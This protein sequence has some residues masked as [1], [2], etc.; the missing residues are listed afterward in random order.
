VDGG[1]ATCTGF[2][3]RENTYLN[4]GANTDLMLMIGCR[5]DAR[6]GA[7]SS[8]SGRAVAHCPTFG[9]NGLSGVSVKNTLDGMAELVAAFAD[10]AV[11]RQDAIQGADRA[12]IDALVEQGGIDLRGGQI[13]EPGCSQNIEHTAA[14]FRSKGTR[15]REFGRP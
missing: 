14:F 12:K 6:A 3:D 1:S 11:F 9:Q 7:S 10:P 5:P 2:D 15:R 8:N 13:D 4:V